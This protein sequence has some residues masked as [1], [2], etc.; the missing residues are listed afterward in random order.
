VT[1]DDHRHVPTT[2]LALLAQRLAHVFVSTS[3]LCR[4][5]R[6]RGWRRQRTRVHPE[7]PEIGV[8]AKRPNDVWHID[9]TILRLLDGT[10]AYLHAVIDNFSRRILAWRVTDRLLPGGTVAILL[11]AAR[12]LHGAVPTLFADSGSENVNGKVDALVEA[13]LLRRVLA[14]T[15]VLSSNSLIE[16]FWRSL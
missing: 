11:E 4:L 12:T 13:G 10:R 14:Q 3:T 7:S 6:V 2:R 5:V 1:S 9:V 16:A 15:E 8:R